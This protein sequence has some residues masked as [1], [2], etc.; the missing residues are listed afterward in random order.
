MILRCHEF[1]R[2]DIK[3]ILVANY[4]LSNYPEK[5]QYHIKSFESYFSL[6]IFKL[7]FSMFSCKIL[8]FVIAVKTAG[9]CLSEIAKC[10]DF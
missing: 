8:I 10:I 3:F 5:Y 1:F 6:S 4:N 2:S 7:H 9:A